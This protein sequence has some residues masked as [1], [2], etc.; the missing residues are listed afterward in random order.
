MLRLSCLST[1]PTCVAIATSPNTCLSHPNHQG[2][3]AKLSALPELHKILSH[4]M[5]IETAVGRRAIV[6]GKPS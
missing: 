5:P 1:F 3:L 6:R 2:R 4:K